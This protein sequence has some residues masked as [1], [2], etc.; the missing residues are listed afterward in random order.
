MTL[1]KWSTIFFYWLWLAIR[2]AHDNRKLHDWRLGIQ[3]IINLVVIIVIIMEDGNSFLQM[4]K[5]ISNG[6]ITSY[7]WIRGVIDGL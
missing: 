2:N 7:N 4:V 1:L 3:I 5:G 6:C